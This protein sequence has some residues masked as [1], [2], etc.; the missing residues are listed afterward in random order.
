MKTNPESLSK[1][2]ICL[3]RITRNILFPFSKLRVYLSRDIIF[4]WRV[5]LPKNGM[6]TAHAPAPDEQTQHYWW[7][8]E[9]RGAP[10]IYRDYVR[11]GRIIGLER[12]TKRKGH[13]P[14]PPSPP[15]PIALIH[16]LSLSISL[17]FFRFLVLIFPLTLLGTILYKVDR[18]PGF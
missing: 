15:L 8:E 14:W 17:S 4:I 12:T 13:F 1:S 2:A 18:F 5:G 16:S 11:H 9:R 3:S 10:L 6:L 7:E